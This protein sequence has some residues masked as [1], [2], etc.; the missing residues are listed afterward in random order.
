MFESVMERR[1]MWGDL[2]A[3]GIVFYPRYYEWFDAAAHQFFEAAG[4]PHDRLWEAHGMVFGLAE[5]RCRYLAAGRYH[6]RVKIITR[7]EHLHKRGLTLHHAVMQ[8]E[9]DRTMVMGIEKRIC[10]HASDPQRLKIAT[11]PETVYQT[12]KNAMADR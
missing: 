11:I 10:M 12:L 2:D 9:T 1:I 3:L 7:L 4:I 6:Q 8:G 5:T